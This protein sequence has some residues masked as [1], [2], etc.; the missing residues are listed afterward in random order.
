[1]LFEGSWAGEGPFVVAVD[2]L[3]RGLERVWRIAG[4]SPR[5]V[6]ARGG[7]SP[8]PVRHVLAAPVPR[9]GRGRR[10]AGRAAAPPRRHRVGGRTR[11]PVAARAAAT[12][13]ALRGRRGRPEPREPDAGHVGD[14]HLVTRREDRRG[15]GL[16]PPLARRS[17]S[18]AMKLIERTR[19]TTR[20]GV[21]RCTYANEVRSGALHA[22]D[23]SKAA[24]HA[25]RS[26]ARRAPPVRLDHVGHR[27]HPRRVLVADVPDERRARTRVAGRA[28]APR[29]PVGR[30]TNGTPVPRRRRRRRRPAVAAPRRRRPRE[31]PPGTLRAKA[32]RIARDGFDR[33][34]SEHRSAPAARVS[35]PVPGPS[36]T[37][38]R[39]GPRRSRSTRNRTAGIREAGPPAL[40]VRD[41]SSKP[42]AADGWTR[43]CSGDIG[44]DR[45][46]LHDLVRG[47]LER[48]RRSAPRDAA[49]RT[50]GP[51]RPSTAR[52]VSS[53]ERRHAV[54]GQP[55]RD[56]PVE[57]RQ[58]GVAV[59][60]EAVQRD[61]SAQEP[62]ADRA[63][64]VVARATRRSGR[65]SR[66][67]TVTPSS[68]PARITTSSSR[69]Q[70]AARHPASFP[71]RGSGS[72]PAGPGRGR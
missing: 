22:S 12:A 68:A 37:H 11:R 36:S 5:R 13:S 52:P 42:T 8:A 45:E 30:R 41:R 44:R 60:R 64:L 18:M 17:V 2:A 26:M 20:S 48:R 31:S 66:R 34:R 49:R 10:V 56:D 1:M 72:R 57:P 6:P 3:A 35:F 16:R 55:A 27:A 71:D 50:D 63:H 46:R 51:R 62:H 61:A 54:V 53:D 32:C 14:I 24:R 33:R 70:V 25:H 40:V 21:V 67:S 39:P 4:A 15:S 58:V 47:I 7:A 59:E 38:T 28:R 69:A 29:A 65:P 9:G 19:A 43:G 23:V